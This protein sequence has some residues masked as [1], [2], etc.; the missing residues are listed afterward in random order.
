MVV[1][2][3]L[4]MGSWKEAKVHLK[5]ELEVSTSLGVVGWS[6]GRRSLRGS[7]L[8]KGA[9]SRRLMP[10]SPSV[11]AGVKAKVRTRQNASSALPS[12]NLSLEPGL[13]AL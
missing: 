4:R 1:P 8:S 12:S 11:W 3:D 10:H 7:C 9:H 2:V 6:L 13:S 5:K